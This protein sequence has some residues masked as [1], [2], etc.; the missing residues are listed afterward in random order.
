MQ[1]SCQQQQMP[2]PLHPIVSSSSCY[3]T[4]SCWTCWVDVIEKVVIGQHII[5]WRNAVSIEPP[6]VLAKGFD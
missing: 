2:M 1:Q 5:K 3:N 6:P 4:T